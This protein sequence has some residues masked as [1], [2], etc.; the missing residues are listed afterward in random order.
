MKNNTAIS[1]LTQKLPRGAVGTAAKT[2]LLIGIFA[3]GFLLSRTALFGQCAPFGLG[4]SAGLYGALSSVASLGAAIGYFF[5]VTGTGGFAYAA[6]AVLIAGIRFVLT[7]NIKATRTAAFA[8][9]LGLFSGL[10][11]ALPALIVSFSVKQFL[12]KLAECSVSACTAACVSVASRVLT[13]GGKM[14]ALPQR[15]S[16]CMTVVAGLILSSLGF[17]QISDISLSG[18]AAAILIM[19]A[20]IGGKSIAGAAAGASL[21]FFMCAGGVCEP[22]GAAA[23]AIGGLIAGV[24]SEFGEIGGSIAYVTGVSVF[25]LMS[26]SSDFGMIFDACAGAV[27]FLILPRKIKSVIAQ[28]FAPPAEMPRLDGMR[29]AVS[30]RLGFASKALCDVSD[31]VEAVAERLEKLDNPPLEKV[32]P[33]IEGKVCVDC[34]MR[35]YCWEEQREKTVAQ[36]V[37]Y[38]R[39]ESNSSVSGCGRMYDLHKAAREAYSQFEARESASAR[40][41]EVREAMSD[42]YTGVADL[43][44]EVADEFERERTFDHDAAQ[45]VESA[46]RSVD[47]IPSDIGCLVDKYG[48]MTVEIRVAFGDRARFN[49]M[50]VMHEVSSACAREFEPPCICSAAG[51]GTLITLTEKARLN[52]DTGLASLTCGDGKLCG[53]TAEI[54]AD[55]RG[56]SVMILSDGMGT[57]GRAAV[58]SA[59]VTGLMERLIKAGFGYDSALKIV[60]SSLRFKSSDESLATVDICSVDLFTGRTEL[61]KAGACP[62]IV[63]R[64][65]RTAVAE[66][67]SLPA[68]ILRDVAFDTAAVTLNKGDIVV[69][70]SDGVMTDGI[71]WILNEVR[72]WNGSTAQQLAEKLASAARRRRCDG[73]D[74]DITVAVTIIE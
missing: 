41:R 32:I 39:G 64:G 2:G 68:G 43:L 62:T 46:L 5:P 10:I 25:T 52:V 53:D 73:H 40:I 44:A 4:F 65:G 66:C 7:D 1:K 36:I 27:I 50:T 45:R 21:G 70:F 26:G 59:M 48:R 34:S 60:N 20:A 72:T 49:K 19:C 51:R 37:K 23:L 58:D 30:L 63:L 12:I 3:A 57:G 29:K 33:S 24:L 18:I 16:M 69:I 15:E 67:S 38:V 17:A 31:T 11:A 28:V 54:F 42:Q 35:C 61:F 47:I 71:K 8:A 22:W 56:H 14:S 9:L 55:G 74:D 13:S 6:A